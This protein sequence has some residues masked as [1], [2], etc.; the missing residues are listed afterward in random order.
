MA[1]KERGVAMET[2][3]QLTNLGEYGHADVV[4]TGLID[5][6]GQLVWRYGSRNG[7]FSWLR[8]ETHCQVLLVCQQIRAGLPAD[9]NQS[10]KDHQNGVNMTEMR[11]NDQRRCLCS[12]RVKLFH[13]LPQHAGDH[14]D[15]APVF[16]LTSL[17]IQAAQQRSH[18]GAFTVQMG[19]PVHSPVMEPIAQRERIKYYIIFDY[20]I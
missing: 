18:R 1:T 16:E 12:Y 15:E 11:E 3:E 13:L 7:F 9:D 2:L 17:L 20:L 4:V 5:D 10:E 14:P 19:V 6:S 8:R